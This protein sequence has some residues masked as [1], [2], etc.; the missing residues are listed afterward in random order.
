MDSTPSLAK[1]AES[2]VSICTFL[3]RRAVL[4]ERL[5]KP[6]RHPE[7]DARIR[8]ARIRNESKLLMEARRIGVRTPLVYDIDFDA[9]SMTL[10]YM[11]GMTVKDVL[12]RG[13]A[14]IEGILSD[15][16]TVV[17]VLHNNG[18]THG[19]LT[20]SNMI[21][22]GRLTILD[23]SMGRSDA[24]LEDMGV[25]MI[26]M[27]R[28]FESAHASSD[29]AFETIKDSYLRAKVD[30]DKVLKKVKEVKGRGRYT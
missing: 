25:D 20:T 1:G 19:D 23:F 26:L 17:A 18:I 29:G 15:I 9:G 24:E 3:G 14:D 27:E 8:A 16:G 12:N 4:K 13:T 10:E 22:N 5:A 28:A 6:Y 21:W 2:K 7:L 11:E 30:G